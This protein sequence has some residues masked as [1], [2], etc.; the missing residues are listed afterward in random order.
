MKK[1]KNI[2]KIFIIAL[3]A[4]YLFPL[5][6]NAELTKEQQK[7]VANFAKSFVNEGNDK[8]ILRYSQTNRAKGYSNQLSTCTKETSVDSTFKNKLAFDCSSFACFVYNQTC[9]ANLG[10]LDTPGLYSSSKFKKIGL[11]SSNKG[12]LQKGDLLCR[13]RTMGRGGH[14]M[15][16]VGDG[17][18]AHASG[19]HKTVN[20]KSVQRGATEQVIVSDVYDDGYTILRYNGSPSKVKGYD[21]YTWPDG[22]QSN[23]KDED[24]GESTS[25]SSSGSSSENSADD[26]E[27]QGTQEGTFNLQ[28]YDI[29]WLIKCLKEILDWIIGITTYLV[30]MVFIGFTSLAEITINDI[31]GKMT[32]EEMSLTIEKLVNNK[33]PLLD[34]NFFNLKMAG[35]QEINTDSV[36][37]AIR[38]SVVVLYYIMRTVSIVSL[39]IT[40]LYLGIRM[41]I[42]SV[43]EDKAKYK[44]MLVNWLVS[45]IIVFFIHYVMIIILYINE[46]LIELINLSFAGGEESLYDSVRSAAYAIQASIGW[47]ALVMYMCLIY[48]LIKFIFIYIKRYLVVAILTFMAPILGISYSIDKIKDNKSQSLSNWLKEYTFNVLLQ[49]IH[50]LLYTVFVSL[51]FN[52]LGTSVVGALFALLLINFMLKAE[53]IFKKIFGVQS[54]SI[55]DAMKSTMAIAYVKKG[56]RTFARTN[57]KAVGIVTKPIRK[58]INNIAARTK[59]YKV[60]D[61]VNKVEK[62]IKTAKAQ[63]KSTVKVGK[64]EYNIGQIIQKEGE[65]DLR[66]VAKGLVD[67]ESEI[68][69]ANKDATKERMLQAINSTVG[70]AE[71]IA[72]IPMT[73]VDGSEGIA[74]ASNA[75]NSLKNGINQQAKKIEKGIYDKTNKRYTGKNKN[76]KRWR[77]NV[78]K[79]GANVATLGMY[80][81]IKNNMALN[82]D[83]NKKIQK[84]INNTQH[85][86]AI[87]QLEKDINKQ[88]DELIKNPNIDRNELEDVIK[89]ANKTVSK[90]AIEKV[91]YR[92][93]AIQ[94]IDVTVKG[95]KPDNVDNIANTEGNKKQQTKPINSKDSE[96]SKNV[97]DNKLDKEISKILGT[98]KE[99]KNATNKIK[100]SLKFDKKDIKIN[101]EQFD[102][103]VKRQIVEVMVKEDKAKK[104]E[105]TEDQ[106][107]TKF[108]SLDDKQK[109]EIFENALYSSTK[110]L[111]VNKDR[112]KKEKTK[113]GLKE[114]NDIIDK[115]SQEKNVSIETNNFKNNFKDA[116]TEEVSNK[117]KKNKQDVKDNEL[118][119]YISNLSNEDLIQKMREVGSKENS[120]KRHESVTKQEYAGLTKSIEKLRYHKEQMKG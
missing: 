100:K 115:L 38:Q 110:V 113:I 74:M 92:V 49:S 10:C 98:T 29:D 64:N 79:S 63:G 4:L 20:R 73:I 47:P 108:N 116:I 97:I 22:T 52:M 14:V 18:V 94:Q 75:R 43:A 37:Y 103:S 39:I 1:L 12:K 76:L 45:F 87:A 83:H 66:E 53:A 58:P 33:V 35:G 5:T 2:L 24:M 81:N 106:L 90:E 42:S 62:A 61:K 46:S 48:L 25:G 11:Y 109:A 71:A 17:K 89:S 56:V 13:P 30:R 84:A 34:V 36:I 105:I 60:E 93:S 80:G 54:G 67:K 3:I 50:A 88:Y 101:E 19:S 9:K 120:I 59:Q 32:G 77:D 78:I 8:K 70:T 51:A 112:L 107:E 111:K 82:K 65:F 31:A 55:K 85:E 15:V 6:S 95:E 27:Y 7:M 23:W 28:T 41:A 40:L 99:L 119:E 26:Y 117:K 44:E 21:E 57:A 102:K 104:I 114:A 91:V 86:I 69:K 72:S 118:D 16:Y 68:K 96:K